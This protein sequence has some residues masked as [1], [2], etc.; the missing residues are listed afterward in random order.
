MITVI[1]LLTV[2]GIPFVAGFAIGYAL[3]SY[4]SLARRER[5]YLR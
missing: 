5:R 4:A 3:R 2:T 1:E